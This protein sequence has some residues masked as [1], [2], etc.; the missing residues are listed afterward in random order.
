MVK[1]ALVLAGGGARGSYELGVWKA[2][3]EMDIEIHMVTGTSIGAINGAAIAQGDFEL[4]ITLW[5]IIETSHVFDININEN[6]RL[7]R[8]IIKTYQNF[9]INALKNGG[10]ELNAL[11]NTLISFIDEKA[12]RASSIEFGLVTYEMDT[13]K[14][15]ELFISDIPNGELI[16]YILA[17]A[18]IYPVFR[19]HVINN[20]RFIDGAY[21]DNLPIK[22]AIE[23]GAN[24]II[25]VD[26]NA[27]GIIN[28]ESFSLS[29]S[30]TYIKSYWN[31]GPTLVF[32]R[33]EIRRN[34]RLGYLDTF[35]AFNIYE[36]FAFTYYSGFCKEV[37]NK[38]SHFLPL[39]DLIQKSGDGVINQFFINYVEKV[40][41]SR[42]IH[43]ADAHSIGLICAELAGEIF[44]LSNEVIYSHEV[45][46]S[47]IRSKIQEFRSCNND[48]FNK[49]NFVNSFI[50]SMTTL[51][52]KKFKA[53]YVSEIIIN[54][55]KDILYKNR[56]T[57]LTVTPE[58]FLA[59][60]Y[61]ASIQ[62]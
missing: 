48:D 16:E 7:D 26:L 62:N 34:I 29:R 6:I 60:I 36:G 1:T 35:K 50:D 15:H 41:N 20:V 40:I 44:E 13:K 18:S 56:F 47:I 51:T 43:N 55:S 23:K 30:L 25:A 53:I 38:L 49:I 61:L 2:L 27:F 45:W 11:K 9:I 28:N 17:S 8:K 42:H 22:M 12:V 39:E 54:L 4:A 59:G 32:D 37:D 5:K 19:P 3:R 31:L 33:E 21:Y 14:P 24:N 57:D 52:C 10:T 58:I 46:L